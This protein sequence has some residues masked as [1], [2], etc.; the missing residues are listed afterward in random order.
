M[1]GTGFNVINNLCYTS[2]AAKKYG[3]TIT[4]AMLTA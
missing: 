2:D 4:G 3:A 1:C